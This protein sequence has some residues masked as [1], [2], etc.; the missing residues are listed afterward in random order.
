MYYPHS[1][2]RKTESWRDHV[3]SLIHIIRRQ[4]SQMSSSAL[5]FRA[6]PAGVA[7][8]G[9][10]GAGHG[11]EQCKISACSPVEWDPDTT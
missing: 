6:G 8:L 5:G 10:S 2:D 9:Q 4:P 7:V 1:T 3:T 11:G